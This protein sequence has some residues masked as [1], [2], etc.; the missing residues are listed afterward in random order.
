MESSEAKTSAVGL[1]TGLVDDAQRIAELHVELA[2]QEL[3]ELAI[4]N[5]IA[6]GLLAVAGGLV[7][8]AVF[9]MVPVVVVT[10]RPDHL[11]WALIF[12]VGYL[13]AGIALAVAGRLLLRIEPPR[14]TLETLKE[15]REWVLRQ[16][17][18]N[19]R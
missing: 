5:A 11:R 7:L 17:S 6:V 14:R 9:V 15:T 4:R 19:G 8:V 1:A 16:I 18:L 12:L 13:G 2:K 10:W 3:K